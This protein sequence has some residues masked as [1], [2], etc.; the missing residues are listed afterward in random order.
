[1]CVITLPTS[2]THTHTHTH[3]YTHIHC[4]NYC[5]WHQLRE[6]MVHRHTYIHTHTHTYTLITSMDI[7]AHTSDV[8]V[9]IQGY[10]H[11]HS[12]T[13][14]HTLR[15]IRTWEEEN[16]VHGM[17]LQIDQ[18][19]LNK[20]INTYIHWVYYV[21][22]S[23]MRTQRP[24]TYTHTHTHTYIHTYMTRVVVVAAVIYKKTKTNKKHRT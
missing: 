23:L 19:I 5:K 1:M 8:R 3:T 20:K 10:V 7:N 15:G 6:R 12:H 2:K 21:H 14:T 4:T 13:H 16:Y 24:I 17:C 22:E 11:T 9:S 18:K